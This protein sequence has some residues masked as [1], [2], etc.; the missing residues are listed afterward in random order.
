[1]KNKVGDLVIF[2]GLQDQ[3]IEIITGEID[4]KKPRKP[5]KYK[6]KSGAVV[7]GKTLKKHAKKDGDKNTDYNFNRPFWAQDLGDE[8]DDYCWSADD[9]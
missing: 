4:C 5:C 8:W 7:F 9:F 2:N 3:I 6:L 1:M